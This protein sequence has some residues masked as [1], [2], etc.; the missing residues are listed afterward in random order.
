MT[1]TTENVPS[2][3][4]EGSRKDRLG[5][6][7]VVETFFAPLADLVVRILLPLRLPP[8]AVVLANAA[9]GLLAAT[10][11]VRGELV[12]AALLLQVK[13]LL[14]NADGQLAR[15]ASRVNLVGRYLDTEAD[16][17]VNAVLLAA[18]AAATGTWWLALGAFLSLTLV[19][20]AGFN[21]AELHREVHGI[22]KER[23]HSAGASV[24]RALELVYRVVFAPQ[25][26]L[27]RSFFSR[28][29][30]R[31]L[32]PEP[33]TEHRRA[34]TL[35]YYDRFTVTALANMG[36]STQLGV[37]G[38]CLVLGRPTAYLW[39]AL[40]CAVA[41][42]VLQVRRERLARMALTTAPLATPRRAA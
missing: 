26:R 33:D 13:T 24:E 1:V 17:V 11:L 12:V 37:L 16:L 42:A 30:E 22:E 18:L 7:L 14:D 9:A 39:F 32:V 3:L 6:E 23:P 8:P 41:L 36:L 21:I 40:A 34:A 29:L 4:L 15:A 2:G 28:R 31:L 20:S 35:A 25:D 5:R 38:A 19:L 10:A 27:L